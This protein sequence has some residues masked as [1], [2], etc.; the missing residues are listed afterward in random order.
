MTMGLRDPMQLA[1]AIVALR[2]RVEDMG[3]RL[4]VSDD[5]RNF[6]ELRTQHR[7]GK[8]APFFDPDVNVGLDKRGFWVGAK[9]ATGT[10][11]CLQAFR[12]DTV[13]PNLADWAL[14][15][16]MGLY[17]RRGELL[18]PRQISPPASSIS[19]R[20]SG[21][22]AYHGELWIDPKL[23]GNGLLETLPRMGMLLAVIKWQPE[24]I[25]ALIGE[26]MATRGQITRLG[27]NHLERGFFQWEFVPQGADDV[28]WLAI[29]ERDELEY[30]IQ[31]T[32]V[33][34]ASVKV[35]PVVDQTMRMS[36]ASVISETTV[37]PGRPSGN[38]CGSTT[39]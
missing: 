22:I 26:S 39:R 21:R 20:I 27:Y 13:E 28:E 2:H 29:A 17:L 33:G 30:L 37:T 23:R 9:N 7:G 32:K 38:R 3:Y 36:T 5:F 15:W 31:Q 35:A 18:V 25:W 6:A 10:V 1:S 16:H 34:P 4:M 11:V 12:I 14:G 19:E 24:A 8:V